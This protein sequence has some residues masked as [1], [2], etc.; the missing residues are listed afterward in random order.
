[1]KGASWGR[2]CSWHFGVGEVVN[3]ARRVLRGFVFG[4]F[5]RACRRVWIGDVRFVRGVILL[6][7][8]T[9]E[10]ERRGWS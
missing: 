10:E 4:G 3:V 1:M 9:F 6:L 5:V 7:L 2:P 8:S